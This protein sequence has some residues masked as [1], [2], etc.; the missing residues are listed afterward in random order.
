MPD[1]L[2]AARNDVADAS[3]TA[4]EDNKRHSVYG[5]LMIRIRTLLSA[6]G[7]SIL[8]GTTPVWADVLE[9]SPS[10]DQHAASHSPVWGGNRPACSVSFAEPQ[11]DGWVRG[12]AK[13][14]R[15]SGDVEIVLELETDSLGKGPCGKADA[16][17]WGN[18]KQLAQ[19]IMPTSPAECMGGK[20]PGNAVA[21]T[22]TVRKSV[23]ASVAAETD[24]IRVFTQVLGSHA[25]YFDITMSTEDPC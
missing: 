20:P 3:L 10:N 6:L 14:D 11:F 18:G 25:G 16:E 7:I 19:L 22:I 23:P 2:P 8:A 24:Q 12:W 13:V 1:F 17:L 5:D 15:S 9:C 4:V 21:R